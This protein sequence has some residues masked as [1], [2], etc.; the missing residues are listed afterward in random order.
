M[1]QEGGSLQRVNPSALGVSIKDLGTTAAAYLLNQAYRSHEAC[2]RL[3]ILLIL[4]LI[5]SF[6]FRTS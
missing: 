1:F 6:A 5:F 3:S 2:G 4:I